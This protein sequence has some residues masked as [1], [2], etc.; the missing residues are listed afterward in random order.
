LVDAQVRV[1][2]PR[3]HKELEIVWRIFQQA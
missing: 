2:L 1:Y 3:D